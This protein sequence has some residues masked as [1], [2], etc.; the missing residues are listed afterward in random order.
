MFCSK[1]KHLVLSD[2][3]SQSDKDDKGGDREG[4]T[5][6]ALF[7]EAGDISSE[8]END[9]GK[10]KKISDDEKEEKEEKEMSPRDEEMEKE[11]DRRDNEKEK[12][13][14]PEEVVPETRIEH[15]IP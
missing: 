11:E 1:R 10:K 6:E 9:E 14:E 2:D 15:E 4:A 12:E 13:K 3:E 5:A 8:E 7:G